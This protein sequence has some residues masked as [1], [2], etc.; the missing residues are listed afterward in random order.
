MSEPEDERICIFCGAR[1]RFTGTG[2]AHPYRNLESGPDECFFNG[3]HIGSA[4]MPILEACIARL[5]EQ[6][7]NQKPALPFL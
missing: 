6:G 7:L 1:F 4:R 3:V 5:K 2:Y